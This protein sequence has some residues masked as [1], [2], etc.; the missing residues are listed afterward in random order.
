[1][2]PSETIVIGA[3]PGGLATCAALH[4]SGIPYLLLEQEGQIAASWHN[5]Y[6][7]LH[8]HTIKEVSALPFRPFPEDFPRYVSRQDLIRYL[9]D[10]ARHF[11]ITPVFHQQVTAIRKTGDLWEV[12]TAGGA[13]RTSRHVI[14]TTGVNRQPAIPSF[15]GQSTFEGPFFH[16]RKYKSGADFKGQ[17]VLVVGMGNTGAEIALDLYEHGAQPIISVRD[18]VNIV[19]REFLGRPTQLTA[20]AMSKLPVAIADWVGRLFRTIAVG[21][22]SRYGI[23]TPAISPA[24]QLATTGK[25]PVLDVGTVK[26]IKS[27]HIKVF[28]GIRR[29]HARGVEGVDGRTESID[30]VVLCTGYRA[31]L[32][33]L[34][35]HHFP[36]LND[37]GLPIEVIGSGIAR[38][39]FFV[40]FNN[41]SP[42][43]VLSMIGNDAMLVAETISKKSGST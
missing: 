21:D 12:E 10:Y 36:A 15:E 32:D 31:G 3:G 28:P 23:R 5:H 18:E 16:S 7:R 37:K 9:N 26:A 25:T 40:G 34:L 35:G 13:C 8:L 22:L 41:F 4:Q 6:D 14:L 17:R 27:G 2:S 38:G 24:L 43:G 39:L 29:F 19:P 20:I 30:A 1:M 42:K 33:E 11:G